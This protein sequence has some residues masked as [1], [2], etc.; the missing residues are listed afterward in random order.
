MV[1]VCFQIEVINFDSHRRDLRRGT[2]EE[3][4]EIE[5][6]SLVFHR[7]YGWQKLQERGDTLLQGSCQGSR[8][9]GLSV[10]V[11]HV[12]DFVNLKCQVSHF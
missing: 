4:V 12:A 6:E 2:R 10:P 1:S 7:N 5:A 9:E 11:F 3:R 8:E